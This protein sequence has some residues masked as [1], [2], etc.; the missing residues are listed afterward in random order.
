MK[1]VKIIQKEEKLETPSKQNHLKPLLK[2]KT[3]SK[4]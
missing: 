4:L 3:A 1:I 2:L